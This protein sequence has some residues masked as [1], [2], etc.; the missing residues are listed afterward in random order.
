[1]DDFAKESILFYF[2]N[3]TTTS[4]SIPVETVFLFSSKLQPNQ[5][6]PHQ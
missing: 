6:P 4:S 1:M 5:H 2:K 3:V